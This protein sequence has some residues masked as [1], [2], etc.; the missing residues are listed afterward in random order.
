MPVV[1]KYHN[2][3]SPCETG[4]IEFQDHFFLMGLTPLSAATMVEFPVFFPND[5]LWKH[6]LKEGE[7]KS[8]C[9]SRIIRSIMAETTGMKLAEVRVEE[10]NTYRSI[11]WPNKKQI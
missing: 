11:L 8:A 7:D 6:H 3:L 2:S 10:K 9:F 1:I 4:A 5:Y